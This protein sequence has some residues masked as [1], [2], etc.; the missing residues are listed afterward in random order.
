M[1]IAAMWNAG[2]IAALVNHLWQSTVLVGVS[3]LLAWVFGKNQARVRYGIWFAASIK[4]LLPFSL[5]IAAGEWLRTLLHHPVA[6]QPAVTA[7]QQVTQ[8]ITQAQVFEIAE[9]R[10]A[11]HSVEWFPAVLL[12]L[13]T[14]GAL[15]VLVRIWRGW[16]QALRAKRTA[17]PVAISADIPVLLSPNSME[18]G[19][20]G[21]FRPVLLLPEGI[22]KRLNAEQ[23]RT[24]LTHEM[25]HMR[26]RDNLTFAIHLA[27]ETL[28]W[29][30]PA[31]WWIGARLIEERERACDEAVLHS[32][33]VPEEYAQGIL[34]VCRFCVDSRVSC[35]AGVTGANLKKR[36]ADIARGRL[37]LR[38]TWRRRFLLGLVGISALIVPMALGLVNLPRLRAQLLL[39]PAGSLPSFDV[40]T[41]KPSRSGDGRMNFRLAPGRFSVENASV[42]ELIR[43]AYNVR[44]DDQIAKRRDSV[45][46]EK[47]DI[48]AK[49]SDV[50]I[51]RMNRLAPDQ[52]FDQYRLM[53]QSLLKDRFKVKV[54]TKSKEVPV[55]ALV[56]TKTG[57]KLT[58]ASPTSGTKLGRMPTLYGGSKGDLNARAVTMKF[59]TDFFLS[60]RSDLNGRLVID[61]TGLQGSYDFTL[62]WSPS[63]VSSARSDAG[64][65]RGGA[66][67]PLPDS[68]GPSLVTA[69][70]EQLGLKL[71]SAK[72][73]VQVL[74]I[75]HV[76]QPTPN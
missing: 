48:N 72:A 43:F 32:G 30:H 28:F 58:Q 35:I 29:F 22:L 20:F 13:W 74:F 27:V 46:S 53:V 49:I 17:R 31:V 63:D 23:L 7:I 11:V 52:R 40:A 59:F 36:I 65:Q 67:S 64:S 71:I 76:E 8:P 37:G 47:F 62:K 70:Q 1:T 75:E 18:P 9:P 5:L 61:A 15:I 45:R 69:L 73:P 54:S 33:G 68:S 16:W 6:E 19:I 55:L 50:Q 26:R 3:W 51:N 24:I 42:A 34:N 21:I 2:W 56:T 66:T 25:C 10:G 38:L 57:P 12:A 39:V 4:F 14:L 41:I 60:G 44:S